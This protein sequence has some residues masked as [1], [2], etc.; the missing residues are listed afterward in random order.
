MMAQDIH[1][2]RRAGPD[3]ATA[4]EGFLATHAA[5]SMFLRANL[6][7]Y[8]TEDRTAQHG[9]TFYVAETSA[10]IA[11]LFGLTNGGYL[12]AQAPGATPAQWAAFADA[13]RGHRVLGMTGVPQQVEHCLTAMGLA[14]ASYRLRA[15]EP[16]YHL[17]IAQM[18]Q[19]AGPVRMARP[20]DRALLEEWYALYEI[21]IGHAQATAEPSP[22]TL[23]RAARAIDSPDVMLLEEG[24]VP[25]SMVG[26]NA[27]LP[28]VVQIGGVYTP[29]P[30]RGRGYARRA[31]AGLLHGCA[32][33]G[34]TQSI[35][36]A[37]NATAARAYAR[38]GYRLIGQYRVAL[39]QAPT[40]I[41]ETT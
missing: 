10:G 32:A 13:V 23:A 19:G 30:L 3:D 20:D 41:G 38:M 40:V 25:V 8:G 26:I 1:A 7:R 35:L 33:Q 11:G 28:D 29:K 18:V 22:A 15:D 6:A 5:T 27:R 39:L 34:V 36:F 37:N 14:T 16:L 24:G 4:V 12:M 2:L 17:E 9:T 21:E 31:L